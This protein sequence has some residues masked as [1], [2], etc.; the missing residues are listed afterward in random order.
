MSTKRGNTSSKQPY[1]SL[2]DESEP[3][4]SE[5]DTEQ[6]AQKKLSAKNSELVAQ[7][8]D[9]FDELQELFK[10]PEILEHLTKAN[11]N[12]PIP[13]RLM[14]KIRRFINKFDIK[15]IVKEVRKHMSGLFGPSGLIGPVGRYRIFFLLLGILVLLNPLA[16]AG[17]GALG[18]IAGTYM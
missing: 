2:G 15:G 14:G 8:L 3:D 13:A 9:G 1:V 18:P 12:A 6:M 4:L 5:S 17:F 7:D 11:H 10:D 16:L